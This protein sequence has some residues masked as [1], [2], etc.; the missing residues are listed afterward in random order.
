MP[1]N[2]ISEI[3]AGRRSM[4]PRRALFIGKAFG[5]GP[6]IWLNLQRACDLAQAAERFAKDVAAIREL[7]QTEA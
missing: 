6:G 4:S 5:I 2:A 1:T 7:Q 3:S